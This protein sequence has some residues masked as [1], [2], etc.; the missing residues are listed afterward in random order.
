M[1]QVLLAVRRPREGRCWDAWG[2]VQAEGQEREERE[3]WLIWGEVWGA[4]ALRGVPGRAP[5]W[6]VACEDDSGGDS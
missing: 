2:R 1:P 4:S 3:K 6:A 5:T